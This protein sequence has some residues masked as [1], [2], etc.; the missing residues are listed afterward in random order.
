MVRSRTVGAPRDGVPEVVF[1]SYSPDQDKGHLFV[2]DAGGNELH[3]IE[4]PGRGAMAVPSIADTNEDGELEIVVSL[5]G[6]DEEGEPQVQLY[7]VPGSA[8]NCMPWPTGRGSLR[9][10]GFVPMD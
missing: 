7:T 1:A 10:D 3:R 5:K 6:N 4:L 9:R 2:L 8:D